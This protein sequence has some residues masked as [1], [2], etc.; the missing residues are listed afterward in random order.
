MNLS[1]KGGLIATGGCG[2]WTV[3][4]VEY[5][6]LPEMLLVLTHTHLDLQCLFL[7]V[8]ML[9]KLSEFLIASLPPTEKV[10]SNFTLGKDTECIEFT[11]DATRFQI[12]Y[13]PP[14]HFLLNVKLPPAEAETLSMAIQNAVNEMET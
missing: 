14:S 13:R 5:A 7:Q 12:K 8:D 6:T 2:N 3:D 4:V 9:V 11:R 10:F 1:E